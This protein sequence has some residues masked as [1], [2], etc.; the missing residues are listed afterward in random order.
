MSKI[1]QT[2]KIGQ[3]NDKFVVMEYILRLFVC[4]SAGFIPSFTNLSLLR[5]NEKNKTG[6]VQSKKNITN[7]LLCGFSC[8]TDNPWAPKQISPPPPT[9]PGGSCLIPSTVLLSSSIAPSIEGGRGVVA[10]L[11]RPQQAE[12]T[13]WEPLDPDSG[14][15]IGS[16]IRIPGQLGDPTTDTRTGDSGRQGGD[17]RSTPKCSGRSIESRA[18]LAN[19]GGGGS[20]LLQYKKRTSKSY[21]GWNFC[22]ISPCVSLGLASS[23]LHSEC[24]SWHLWQTLGCVFSISFKK[25]QPKNGLSW[26]FRF[27]DFSAHFSLTKQ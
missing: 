18:F 17:P 10:G 16:R 24:T 21:N 11:D 6:Q 25:K 7:H 14:T 23:S 13:K 26:L 9:E 3:K 15:K 19:T 1:V 20:S 2:L 8:N 22:L 12:N 27:V 5:L 4:K